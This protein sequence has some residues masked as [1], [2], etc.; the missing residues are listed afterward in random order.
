M[1]LPFGICV[2]LLLFFYFISNVKMTPCGD[3]LLLHMALPSYKLIAHHFLESG[4][5]KE[6]IVQVHSVASL[7]STPNVMV[8]VV[9][10]NCSFNTK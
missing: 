2:F 3:L 6:T 10:L 9:P 7:L 8:F 5:D 1:D 4:H